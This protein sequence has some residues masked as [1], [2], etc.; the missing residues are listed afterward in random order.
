MRGAD[1]KIPV[2]LLLAVVVS[3]PAARTDDTGLEAIVPYAVLGVVGGIFDIG[4]T[5]YDI[6]TLASGEP[7]SKS[8]GVIETALALP[9][10]A[11]AAYVLSAPPPADGVRTLSALWLVWATALAAHG[12]WTCVRPDASWT[13]VRPDD[14]VS[15]VAIGVR[16]IDEARKSGAPLLW[17]V[18]G[19]F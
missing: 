18:S 9:Q 8:F 17:S 15:R 19:R 16:P 14:S 10:M 5:N 13:S 7:P 4:A 2:W 3:A 11:I 6:K 1:V 12:V